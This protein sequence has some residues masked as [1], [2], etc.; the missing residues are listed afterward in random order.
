MAVVPYWYTKLGEPEQQAVVA[1]L[2]AGRLSQ[3]PLVPQLE[4][5]LAALLQVREVVATTS[6]TAALYL[7]AAN[8]G[9]GPGDEV[10]VPTRTFVATA[11]AVMMTGARVRLVDVQPDATVL[12]PA[13]LESA[14][15][16]RTKAIVPVH[17]NGRG[18][19]L[20]AVFA[21][22]ERHGLIVFEDAAQAFASR[23]GSAYLGTRSAAGCFSLGVT[24]MITT[25]QGG[26]VATND[27]E[28][29][30][31]MRRFRSHGVYDTYEATYTHF[32]FNLRLTDMQA[33]IGLVQLGKLDRKIAAHQ[34]LHA[35]YRRALAGLPFVRLLDVDRDRGNVPLWA[36]A[37]FVDRDRALE[38]LGAQQIQARRFLPNLSV[39]AYISDADDAQFPRGRFF[40]AHGAFL[41]S[42]PDLPEESIDRV[43]RAIEAIGDQVRGSFDEPELLAART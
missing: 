19:D 31:R 7:A 11:H 29:G 41:P 6:G 13:Q 9:I 37:V 25:G 32:G 35:R 42:G 39:S 33:A 43:C 14:I 24:K 1:A 4:R 10:I 16:P 27:A 12:D 20:D 17:L 23:D 22:A 21:V 2:A 15:T 5:E 38:L 8:L 40:A 30:E 26:F 18:V 28:L 36:E 3:G 34:Q